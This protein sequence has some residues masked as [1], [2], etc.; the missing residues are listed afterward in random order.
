MCLNDIKYVPGLYKIFDEILVNAKDNFERDPKSMTYIKVV[1][2]EKEG[3]I[4]VENNGQSLPVEMH[5]DEQMY[6]PEMVFG[7][8]LTSDNYDD[9]EKKV[10]GGRNGYGAKLANIFSTEFEVECVDSG[11]K[12]KYKQTWRDNMKQKEKPAIVTHAGESYT[13]ISFKPDLGRFGMKK[14]DKDILGLMARRAVD[15]AG[16][17]GGKIK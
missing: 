3:F 15:V 16:I 8:L 11:R 9:T 12:K 2:D 6:V 14:L 17:T 4:S 13:K 5:S 1:I 10:V 7:H